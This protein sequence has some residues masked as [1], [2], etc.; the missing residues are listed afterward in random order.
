VIVEKC[1]SLFDAG[2]RGSGSDPFGHFLDFV[3][4]IEVIVSLPRFFGVPPFLCIAA[5]CPEVEDLAEGLKFLPDRS[6]K[7]WFVYEDPAR[8]VFFQ[9]PL[10]SRAFSLQLLCRTSTTF[11]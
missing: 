6:G 2:R 11:G 7:F 4:R 1:K 5:V 9:Q 3:A 10:V 8:S